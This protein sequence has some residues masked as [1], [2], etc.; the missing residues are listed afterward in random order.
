MDID[1]GA[2]AL[3]IFFGLFFGIAGAISSYLARDWLE[4]LLLGKPGTLA[5]AVKGTWEGTYSQPGG[6]KTTVTFSLAAFFSRIVYGTIKYKNTQL[7]CVGVFV[8]DRNLTLN[9]KNKKGSVKQHGNALLELD[10]T[11]KKLHG[12]F[13]GYG[14]E[15]NALV[16][17]ILD[18]KLTP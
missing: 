14:P 16:R 15:S 18:L 3:K 17:G 9:Y 12:Y 11:G 6:S 1:W 8:A 7:R 5:G 13:V 10:G 4:A 2:L